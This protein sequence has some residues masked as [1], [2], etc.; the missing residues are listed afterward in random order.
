MIDQLLHSSPR[1]IPVSEVQ[2]KNMLNDFEIIS[3]DVFDTLLIRNCNNPTDIFSWMEKKYNSHCFAKAR[4]NAEAAARKVHK[5]RG[6]EVSIEEIY[7]Q[8]KLPKTSPEI[9]PAMEINAE[10][11]FLSAAPEMIDFVDYLKE[12]NKKVIC[13]S[14]MYLSGNQIKDLLT[15]AGFNI[16]IVISSSDLRHLDIGKYNGRIFP[17]FLDKLQLTSEK[18]LHIGDNFKS[19]VVNAQRNLVSAL[20]VTH[21]ID[22]SHS[23][24][25]LAN[26]IARISK[27]TGCSVIAQSVCKHLHYN[28]AMINNFYDFGYTIG[29]PLVIGFLQFMIK[30]A[31]ELKISHF[32][33]LARDGAIIQQCLDRVGPIPFGYRLVP[34]SRRMCSFAAFAD[35]EKEFLKN[36]IGHHKKL[37]IKQLSKILGF[38]DTTSLQSN[39][40]KLPINELL[41]QWSPELQR[42]AAIEKAAYVQALSSEINLL[43]SGQKIAWADVGWSLSSSRAINSITGYKT[44]TICVGSSSK[45]QQGGDYGY[46]FTKGKPEKTSNKIMSGV[47]IIELIF[48]SASASFI[49]AQYVDDTISFK[50]KDKCQF[51]RQRDVFIKDV[52]AGV[53]SFVTEHWKYIQGVCP[54]SLQAYNREVFSNIL[55]QPDPNLQTMLGRV[56]HDRD[57]GCA[58]MQY[59]S[60]YWA[61]GECG[62]D[63]S[64]LNSPLI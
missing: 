22:A 27:Q 54:S 40:D 63:E 42:L 9:T 48:S 24:Q 33:L 8:I 15:T 50:M 49:N 37:S 14:D 62:L 60:S 55:S 57:P 32:G 20:P 64:V 46:L 23:S 38:S 43:A 34:A 28:H 1:Q 52:T 12:N 56:P 58:N 3:F 16:D 7:A 59:I 17:W 39:D 18:V 61:V 25:T 26:T 47:E 30:K 19:D 41:D 53:I 35:G 2:L 10:K 31:E 29:G 4:V 44:P 45:S 51:E 5:L 21:V 6:N 36:L 11:L 13:M